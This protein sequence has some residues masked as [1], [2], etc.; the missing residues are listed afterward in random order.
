M[1]NSG[2][3]A[4]IALGSNLGDRQ[5]NIRRA[6]A[7]LVES[8][9]IEVRRIS[10]LRLYDAVGG[11]PDAPQFLNAAAQL[12]TTLAAHALMRRL[13]EIE[14][15]MGRVRREKWEPRTI[16]LDLLLYGSSIIASDDLVVPHPLMHERLFVLEP[17]AE[18]AAD[19]MH[20]ILQMTV[21]NL[22][23]ALKTMHQRK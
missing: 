9:G 8:P 20:P 22:L 12:Q 4:Y 21:G 17:L 18:I 7:I 5:A 13:L 3:A 19:A 10:S 1:R 11:P 14:Q 23:A 15:S 16:D 2:V 6:L